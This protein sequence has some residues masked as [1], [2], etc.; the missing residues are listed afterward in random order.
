MPQ[1]IDR[2]QFMRRSLSAAAVA[3]GIARYALAAEVPA[4]SVSP[5]DRIRLGIIGVGARVHSGLLEAALA[6]EKHQTVL[7]I[8]CQGI[9]SRL[10]E[11]AREP[12]A[13]AR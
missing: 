12:A 3:P 7:Q 5:N 9:S 4:T 11:T 6:V 2:R 8:G 10:Q 1:G 13:S